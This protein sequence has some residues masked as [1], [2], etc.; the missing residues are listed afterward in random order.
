MYF[1]NYALF[2][3]YTLAPFFRFFLHNTNYHFYSF[4][5]SGL[6]HRTGAAAASRLFN[7]ALAKIAVNAQQGGTTDI[8]KCYFI[9]CTCINAPKR[10]H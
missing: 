10:I 9:V 5:F 2:M 6:Y 1:S 7:E 8:G 3:L 4:Y